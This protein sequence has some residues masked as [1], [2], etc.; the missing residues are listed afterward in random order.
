[1]SPPSPIG[2]NV[3]MMA[4]IMRNSRRADSGVVDRETAS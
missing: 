3:V 2:E 4:S 1:M